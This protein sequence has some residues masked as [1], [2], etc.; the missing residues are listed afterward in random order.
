MAVMTNVQQPRPKQVRIRALGKHPVIDGKR[1]EELVPSFRH[2]GEPVEPG[3]VVTVTSATR[4]CSS[5]SAAPS[6][7]LARFR[8]ARGAVI[9]SRARR[10]SPAPRT[11]LG[12]GAGRPPQS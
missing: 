7:S 8:R 5:S 11:F 9:L 2:A 12:C 1:S 10:R 4:G 3:Q 6:T